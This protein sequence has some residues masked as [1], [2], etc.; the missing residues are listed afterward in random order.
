MLCL[1]VGVAHAQVGSISPGKLSSA[2][3]A[4]ETQCNRC[5]VPFS[6][7]PQGTCLSC[8]TALAERIAR[9]V[10]LHPKVKAQACTEC[11][12]EHHGRDASVSPPV[13]ASFDHKTASFAADGKHAALACDKC[14]GAKKWVGIPTQCEGCHADKHKGAYGSACAKCHAATGWTP[15]TR[16]EK[17][18]SRR[19]PAATQT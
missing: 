17:I 4:F 5:H 3:A 9:G 10:G 15:T 1:L 2:H 11:H 14:H 7:I 12:K 16:T 8:H 19:S 18:T 6:G 13:P